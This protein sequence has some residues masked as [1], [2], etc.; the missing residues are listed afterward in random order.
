MTYFFRKGRNKFF[1]FFFFFFWLE[2]GKGK[3]KEISTFTYI[4]ICNFCARTTVS[5]SS[6]FYGYT[7]NEDDIFFSGVF[8]K[9]TKIIFQHSI[10]IS[11]R[12]SRFCEN[13]KFQRGFLFFL[14]LFLKW[15]TEIIKDKKRTSRG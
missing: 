2:K 7:A 12:S 5:N 15:K 4:S 1:F 14:S 11:N 8:F 6:A 13:Q 10:K 9:K 3:R